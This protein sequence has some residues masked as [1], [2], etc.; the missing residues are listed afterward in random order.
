[1]KE[2]DPTRDTTMEIHLC[3]ALLATL[4]RNHVLASDDELA[5]LS[6]IAKKLK[7]KDG[8]QMTPKNRALQHKLDDEKFVARLLSAPVDVF[9][10]LAAKSKV[11]KTEFSKIQAALAAAVL[12]IAPVRPKNLASIAIDHHLFRDGD[13]YRLHFPAVEVKNEVDLEFEITG[14]P[15]DLLQTYLEQIR[16][17][18]VEADNPFLFP[19][20]SGAKKASTISVQV[21]DFLRS[22]IGATVTGHQFR[23]VAGYLFLL[24]N[25]GAYEVVRQF[26]G[27]RKVSTTVNYY[28]GMEQRIATRLLDEHMHR[29]RDELTSKGQMRMRRKK[30]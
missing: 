21:K 28:A 17:R 9:Q 1:M 22:E 10:R 30:K 7:P 27:H 14:R 6:A 19:G 2:R 18:F 16:P 15:A 8:H 12:P 24:Y 5:R 20:R 23:H 29:R 4:A 3:A 13:M 11:T 26:L 25:P